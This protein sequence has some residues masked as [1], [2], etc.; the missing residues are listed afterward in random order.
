[1]LVKLNHIYQ[2]RPGG[3]CLQSLRIREKEHEFKA[4]LDYASARPCP[5][6]TLIDHSSA[7]TV[8]AL[9]IP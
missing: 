3:A 5:H 6:G 2:A 4:S 7:H 1:M 8:D 9:R